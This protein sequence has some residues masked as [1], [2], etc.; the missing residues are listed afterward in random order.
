MRILG[1]ILVRQFTRDDG[2]GDAPLPLSVSTSENVVPAAAV[3]TF[4]FAPLSLGPFTSLN[5]GISGQ[6]GWPHCVAETLVCAQ[7]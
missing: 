3:T 5:D 1:D 4:S 2:R 6:A 7:E